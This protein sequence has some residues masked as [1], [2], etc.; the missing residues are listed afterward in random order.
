MDPAFCLFMLTCF[1]IERPFCPPGCICYDAP[2]NG[3]SGTD[4]QT[5]VCDS[6]NSLNNPLAFGSKPINSLV[7]SKSSTPILIQNPIQSNSQFSPI[8]VLF[9]A[10]EIPQPGIGQKS[11]FYLLNGNTVKYLA[12]VA[13]TNIQIDWNDL[14][15]LTNLDTLYIENSNL[16][17]LDSTFSELSLPNLR[18]L[19]I[20]YSKLLYIDREALFGKEVSLQKLLLSGN[21][22][23]N[24]LWLCQPTRKFPNLYHL[25]LNQ[26]LL[27]TIPENLHTFV[28]NLQTLNVAQNR[29]NY[30]SLALL[31]PW[32]EIPD[33]I[34]EQT[35]RDQNGKD[36][37]SKIFYTTEMATLRQ[38]ILSSPSSKMWPAFF[39][40]SL[41]QNVRY[42]SP[43]GVYLWDILNDPGVT[44]YTHFPG[45]HSLSRIFPDKRDIFILFDR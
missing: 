19:H 14:K 16:P 36:I 40:E 22:L 20:K 32:L 31:S 9:D 33:F 27:S 25:D 11:I 6:P 3:V 30:Y 39:L 29:L 24:L 13:S 41:M 21:Q 7:V 12:I 28:P 38:N 45:K 17:N 34:L 42:I 1:T 23:R 18:T 35:S 8:S 43:T 37:F 26:N 10:T 15:H 5:I 44:Q 4:A 2:L